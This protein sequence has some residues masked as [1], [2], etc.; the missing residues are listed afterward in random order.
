VKGRWWKNEEDGER[1][2]LSTLEG[3]GPPNRQPVRW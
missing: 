1:R 3:A 2:Q